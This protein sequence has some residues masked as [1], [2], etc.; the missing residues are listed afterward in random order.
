M[1]HF[2]KFRFLLV[3]KYDTLMGNIP[4]SVKKNTTIYV[5]IYDV[6][7]KKYIKYMT[8]ENFIAVKKIDLENKNLT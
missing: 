2:R 1:S 5:Y 8:S 7:I 6:Q 3:S 4:R